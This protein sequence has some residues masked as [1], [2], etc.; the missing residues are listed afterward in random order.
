MN[1]S[2]RN[3]PINIRCIHYI[4]KISIKH[5]VYSSRA[6]RFGQ[7]FTSFYT[8]KTK[9]IFCATLYI[10]MSCSDLKLSCFSTS[11][12]YI[13]YGNVY[14]I[15]YLQASKCAISLLFILFISITL[16]TSQLYRIILRGTVS[17]AVR[18]LLY[19]PI[20]YRIAVWYFHIRVQM[21][22]HLRHIRPFCRHSLQIFPKFA[23][24]I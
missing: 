16:N 5:L 22:K 20:S 18:I 11:Q 8:F 24:A 3:T 6:R 12:T 13:F 17:Q 19:L 4:G 9:H 14:N 2:N 1:C 10:P 21:S 23:Q 15:F 7:N